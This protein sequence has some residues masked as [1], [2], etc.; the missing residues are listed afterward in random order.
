VPVSDRDPQTDTTWTVYTSWEACGPISETS[1]THPAWPTA[2]SQALHLACLRGV[3]YVSVQGPGDI[4]AGEYDRYT[5]TWREY[6]WPFGMC[7]AERE[8]DGE[9][10]TAQMFWRL[11]SAQVRCPACRGWHGA[12]S[13]PDWYAWQVPIEQRRTWRRNP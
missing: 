3:R 7:G 9:V 1:E 13:R 2:R 5:N 10:C 11:G 8:P 12:L 6:P 4:V